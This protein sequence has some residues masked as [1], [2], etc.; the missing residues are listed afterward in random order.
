[1]DLL[2]DEQISERLGRVPGWSRQGDS[3]VHVQTLADF[4]AAV[5][6]VGAVA[7]LAEAANHHPD[8]TIQWNK[9]TLTLST[10]SAGGLTVNDF[11][12]AEQ[13]NALS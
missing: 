5:L 11:A 6:Y 2:T 9:V 12:L 7:Y 8:I 13:I 4:R 1:M 3:I 10:H